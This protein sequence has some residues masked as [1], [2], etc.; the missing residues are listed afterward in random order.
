VQQ[1]VARPWMSTS[2][3]YILSTPLA[4]GG[5]HRCGFRGPGI[6]MALLLGS[7]GNHL[8][9]PEL[10]WRRSPSSG[11]SLAQVRTHAAV[12]HTVGLQQLL[13]HRLAHSIIALPPALLGWLSTRLCSFPLLVSKSLLKREVNVRSW[14]NCHHS[15]SGQSVLWP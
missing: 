4:G 10:G 5:G 11:S 15:L 7:S 3:W 2:W 9:W 6:D 1:A 12:A 14:W 8:P 13:A